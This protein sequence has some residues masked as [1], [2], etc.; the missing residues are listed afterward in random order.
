LRRYTDWPAPLAV[1]F[2]T[3]FSRPVIAGLILANEMLGIYKL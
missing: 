2:C 1:G 3:G